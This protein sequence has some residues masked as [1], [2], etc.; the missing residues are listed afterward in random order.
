MN[1]L[2]AMLT[3]VMDGQKLELGYDAVDAKVP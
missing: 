3:M 1:C 2:A